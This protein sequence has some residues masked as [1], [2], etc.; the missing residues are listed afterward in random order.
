M[1]MIVVEFSNSTF[2]LAADIERAPN[3]EFIPL[4]G[5]RFD[6]C[7]VCDRRRWSREPVRRGMIRG[8]VQAGAIAR[9]F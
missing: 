3:V 9:L 5:F 8:A 4:G 1:F 7:N 2:G 6:V